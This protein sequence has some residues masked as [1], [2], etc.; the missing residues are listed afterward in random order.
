MVRNLHTDLHRMCRL[1]CRQ[2][3]HRTYCV[4]LLHFESSQI[5]NTTRLKMY[6]NNGTGSTGSTVLIKPRFLAQH[7]PHMLPSTLHD[8][9]PADV[10]NRSQQ[11]LKPSHRWQVETGYSCLWRHC[12]WNSD[13]SFPSSG[14]NRSHVWP[15]CLSCC[16]FHS[17]QRTHT[18]CTWSISVYSVS[19]TMCTCTTDMLWHYYTFS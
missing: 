8:N 2:N 7:K 12:Q 1:K 19:E 11:Y 9:T 15:P 5:N 10:H 3:R 16:I 13:A 14:L 17:L 4:R 18:M 6:T